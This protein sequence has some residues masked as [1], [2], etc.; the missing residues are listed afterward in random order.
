MC[1]LYILS[2]PATRMTKGLPTEQKQMITTSV[3]DHLS[4]KLSVPLQ[5]CLKVKSGRVLWGKAWWK[6]HWTNMNFGVWKR[7]F[8]EG[9]FVSVT[10]YP[11]YLFW[12]VTSFWWLMILR[13]N[14]ISLSALL[15]EGLYP[16]QAGEFLPHWE[17]DITSFP[18]VCWLI[19]MTLMHF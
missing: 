19:R 14:K 5:R 13:L 10:L 7:N 9:L 8:Y 16:V 1:D 12:T 6:G 15:N 4:K 18:R 2:K 3:L 17:R 11:E